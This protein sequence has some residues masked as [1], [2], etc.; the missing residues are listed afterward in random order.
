LFVRSNTTPVKK[1]SRATTRDSAN[2]SGYGY[3]CVSRVLVARKEYCFFFP[4][5]RGTAAVTGLCRV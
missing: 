5:P 2:D 4:F 1:Q 3:S